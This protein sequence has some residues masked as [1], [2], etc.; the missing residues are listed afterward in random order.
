M[1]KSLQK[2]LATTLLTASL[3]NPFAKAAEP[4]Y[5]DLVPNKEVNYSQN[6][7]TKDEFGTTKTGNA[8]IST[9]LE[10]DSLRFR[11][12][13]LTQIG[14][15]ERKLP[16]YQ[17]YIEIDNLETKL[18]AVHPKEVKPENL[19]EKAYYIPEGWKELK[20]L[21]NSPIALLTLAGGE[22]IV[23]KTLAEIPYGNQIYELLNNYADKC[24]K[25][26]QEKILKEINSE[27]A[28]TLLDNYPRSSII[29]GVQI[30]KEY[31]LDF[32]TQDLVGDMPVYL[33]GKSGFKENLNNGTGQIPSFSIQFMLKGKATPEEKIDYSN[34]NEKIKSNVSIPMIW[35]NKKS[36][37]GG[38]WISKYEV[39]QEQYQTITGNNPSF[40]KNK[41]NPVE[42]TS[43]YDAI[44]FCEK[45]SNK[46][47][48]KYTLPRENQWEYAAN[49]T[50][51]SAFGFYGSESN[52]KN[53]AWFSENSSRKT[54][55]TG[56]K[57]KNDFGI[58]DLHGNVSEWTITGENSRI[59]KGGNFLSSKEECKTPSW[60]AFY[61][62]YKSP[63]QGFRI[64]RLP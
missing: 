51:T 42:R 37:N 35:L 63:T 33:V 4:T 27:Y 40:F 7:E 39:S 22:I 55:T 59:S 8:I 15:K 23:R 2:I 30:S 61:V 64:I 29:S 1:K 24:E 32:N 16:K 17:Q 38:F 10:N 48:R 62:E 43:W 44:N 11:L 46:T 45:L 26:N 50:K 6:I 18:Y 31:S 28:I 9:K 5:I 36:Q 52:L 60:N 54:H 19:R 47:K 3:L 49:G 58:Y 21:Y 34:Y 20:P 13:L 12:T 57:R 56:I 41:L 14:R 25:R 53:Y